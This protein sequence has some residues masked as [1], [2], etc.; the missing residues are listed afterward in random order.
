MSVIFTILFVVVAV[1]LA[2]TILIQQGKGEIGLSGGASQSGQLI[3]GGS[4]G[5]TFFEKLTWV[6]GALFIAGSLFLSLYQTKTTTESV[7]KGYK[8]EQPAQP[9]PEKAAQP[10]QEKAELPAEPA[11]PVTK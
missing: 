5:A 11:A 1:L 4:G 10:A 2:F 8:V 9:K 3:F 7:L 6:L